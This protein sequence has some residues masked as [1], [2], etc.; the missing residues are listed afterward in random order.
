M[1]SL[2]PFICSVRNLSS[3]SFRS[4]PVILGSSVLI[5]GLAQGNFNLM[6][7]FIGMCIL[8]PTATLLLKVVW[9]LV[10]SNT[11]NWLTV[12][13]SLWRL[14]G[15]EAAACT[16]FPVMTGDPAGIQ[17][18]VP[19]YWMTMIAFAITYMYANAKMLYDKQA[20]SKA[21]QYAIDARK[22]Q[23][24]MSMMILTAFALFFTIARYASGC[25]T[26]LGM[27]ISWLLGG[28][29][30][31]GWYKFMRACGLGRLDDLFGISNR[32]LPQQAYE[33]QLPTV[34]STAT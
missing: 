15:F 31:F 9:E 13:F 16:I 30:G 28:W 7:F 24:I 3:Q 14:Q 32:I 12:P 10:F 22:S 5:L 34:C 23:A 19:S 6:F 33:D 25:E 27:I 1:S 2:S 26:G 29:L 20:D 8:A 4:L 11:P 18:V 21:P 17:C